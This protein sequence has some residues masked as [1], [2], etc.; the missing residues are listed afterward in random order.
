MQIWPLIQ[1]VASCLFA[2]PNGIEEI[3]VTHLLLLKHPSSVD[4]AP[5]GYVLA[6]TLYNDTLLH[7][8]MHSLF[9]QNI[10]ESQ[11]KN[12]YLQI[13]W[14]LKNNSDDDLWWCLS[15]LN[16]M[17]FHLKDA[18]QQRVATMIKVSPKTLE[19]R[20]HFQPSIHLSGLGNGRRSVEKWNVSFF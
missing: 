10:K 11:A 16:R 20:K 2:K 4:E 17:S 5:L 12:V 6:A 8:L 15:A 14:F 1:R 3:W 18:K 9:F 19:M 13:E 7:L